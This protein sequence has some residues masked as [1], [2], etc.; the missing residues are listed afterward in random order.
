M[1][2]SEKNKIISKERRFSGVYMEGVYMGEE[3]TPAVTNQF[4]EK[5]LDEQ[6]RLYVC[7]R[8]GE[9]ASYVDVVKELKEKFNVVVTE[10]AVRWYKT[11]ERWKN[12][13]YAYRKIYLDTLSVVPL[14]HKKVRVV[15]LQKMFNRL[16]Q[17]GG[18]EIPIV[19]QRQAL[20]IV[21]QAKE[22]GENK[23]ELYKGVYE[24][25]SGES[26]EKVTLEV[27]KIVE[28]LDVESHRSE[29]DN[30][31]V[32]GQIMTIDETEAP[33]LLTESTI[34]ENPVTGA[35]LV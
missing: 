27:L 19:L 18:G 13:I 29:I 4:G 2:S 7:K 1:F 30:E 24:V 3:T 35:P 25:V 12:H 9:F 16:K 22:E 34:V 21:K 32:G 26:A 11:N 17:Q 10:E 23:V 20:D 6:K 5:V 14:V 8:L 15:E 33:K 28:E 31:E